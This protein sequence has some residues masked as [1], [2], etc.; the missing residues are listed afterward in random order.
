MREWDAAFERRCS[1]HV[2]RVCDPSLARGERDR[3]WRALLSDVAPHIESFAQRS[4]LLRRAGLTSEDEPRAVLVGVLERLSRDDFANLGRFLARRPPHLEVAGCDPETERYLRLSRLDEPIDQVSGQVSGQASGQA[5]EQ[6]AGEAA[7]ETP[8][9]AWLIGLVAF[10]VKDHVRTRLGGRTPP[11]TDAPLRSKRDLGTGADRLSTDHEPV[12]RP[13]ITDALA[14]GARRRRDQRVH[15]RLPGADA[16]RAR[17]VARR[18]GLR[19]DRGAPRP[20]EGAGAR[21]GPRR[22]GAPAGALPRRLGGVVRRL[23]RTLSAVAGRSP[24]DARPGSLDT[25]FRGS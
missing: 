21:A 20:A 6:A 11:P 25:P 17:A 10:S 1:E 24:P 8:L 23:R 15:G 4:S 3:S 5:A 9:R 13:A 22:T 14:M 12:A 7:G 18:P 16:Q 19:R 2:A